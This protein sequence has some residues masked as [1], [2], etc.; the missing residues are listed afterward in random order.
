MKLLSASGELKGA[1]S[2]LGKNKK[3]PVMT[4][5]KRGELVQPTQSCPF[6]LP[7]PELELW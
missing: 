7:S 5:N 2:T 4:R 1:N 3:R 6:I